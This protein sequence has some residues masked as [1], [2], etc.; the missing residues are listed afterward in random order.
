MAK[1]DLT[2]QRLRELLDYNP[3]TGAFTHCVPAGRWGRIK[4]GSVAGNVD[5]KG[6]WVVHVDGLSY[7]AHRLA[8]LSVHGVWPS[9][10][11]D[12]IDG[13]KTNNAIA[14]LR[15]ASQGENSQ[16]QR[17]AK[18]N[19]L[20]GFLGVAKRGDVYQ[21]RITINGK[22]NCLGYFDTPELAHD[23]YLSAKKDMHQF[24]EVAKHTATAAPKRRA[25]H[26]RSKS[27]L[28]GVGWDKEAGKWKATIRINGTQVSLGRF[29]TAEQAYQTCLQ[30]K[31]EVREKHN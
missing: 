5:A 4:A 18:K 27:G 1:A 29:S 10:Q 7:K 21:A 20:S 26:D 25:F 2:A 9:G 31:K 16:N 23:A 22:T 19:N 8:W 13:R 30:A 24:G 11:I 17:E 28:P 14:N 6:Y 12:H 15:E 3:E